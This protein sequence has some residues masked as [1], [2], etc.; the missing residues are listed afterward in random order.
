MANCEETGRICT[1]EEME[2][3]EEFCVRYMRQWVECKRCLNCYEIHH[4]YDVYMP[5]SR[6]KNMTDEQAE[7]LKIQA[8]EAFI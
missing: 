4:C 8:T 2:Q 7:E 6:C 5:C 1:Q 3:K